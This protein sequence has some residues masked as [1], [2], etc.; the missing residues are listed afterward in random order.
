M[1]NTKKNTYLLRLDSYNNGVEIASDS[2]DYLCAFV[3]HPFQEFAVT[4]IGILAGAISAVNSQLH[5]MT[6]DLLDNEI[7]VGEEDGIEYLV[8]EQE[9]VIEMARLADLVDEKTEDL[10]E[11]CHIRLEVN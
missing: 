5:Y 7:I 8:L 1:T 3:D 9:Q 6:T 11:Q 10:R 4:D 2:L